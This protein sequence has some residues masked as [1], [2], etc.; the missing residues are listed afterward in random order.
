MDRSFNGFQFEPFGWSRG[1]FWI[2]L[3]FLKRRNRLSGLNIQQPVNGLGL[4]V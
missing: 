4:K 1:F 3:D 2:G